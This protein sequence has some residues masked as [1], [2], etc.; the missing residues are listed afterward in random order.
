MLGRQLY[1]LLLAG[2]LL[3]PVSTLA[4]EALCAEVKIEILQEMTLE[5]QGFEAVMRITNSLDIFPLE[6]VSVTINFA[7]ADGNAVTAT[8]DTNASDAEFFIRLDSSYRVTEL[9]EG[10]N[11]AVLDGR[12]AQNTTSEIRWLIIPTGTAA[13][14]KEDGELYFVGAALSYTYGGKEE[15]V[16]VAPDSIVVKPQP[17]LALDY[18]LTQEVFGDDAFTA[19]IEPPEP[20]VLGI[21][22][23]NNG[24]GAAKN[25]EL[26]SAQPTIVE[27][28]QGLAIDFSI[29]GSFVENK[30][31]QPTLLLNFGEIAPQDIVAGRWIM[32]SSLS[33]EFTAFTA[34]FTHAN[35]LGG[36]VTSLLQS[37]DAHFLQHNV[38]VDLPGRDSVQDFLATV[39]GQLYVLESEPTG[40]SDVF[41]QHCAPVSSQSGILGSFQSNGSRV[42]TT[43]AASG[44]VHIK[45]ADPN[46][47]SKVLNRVVR[48]DGK[49]LSADNV[50][51]SKSRADDKRSFNHFINIFDSSPTAAYTL[52]FADSAALPQPPVIQ[53]I[54]D[55]TAN[56]GGQVGFIVQASDPNGTTPTLTAGAMPTGATFVDQGTGTG[57]FRWFPKVGQ[58][59]DYKVIFTASDG[60]LTHQGGECSR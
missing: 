48:S 30:P 7:D 21:R 36:E 6:D 59:G 34:S 37:T 14:Q 8:S 54:N 25:V 5:R 10:E 50:W 13:G 33:G 23:R 24:F 58:A 12:I 28:E 41:C 29:T 57:V 43:A 22:I 19:E 11:G 32:E 4:E 16:Q 35:E 17:A 40:L 18:F 55:R 44:F 56:E 31:A 52:Y 47:G 46:V 39:Q 9:Q 27:N 3:L 38:T 60:S 45:L 1:H 20:Y 51:L 15:T 42:L 26:E 53:A 49:V 2:L